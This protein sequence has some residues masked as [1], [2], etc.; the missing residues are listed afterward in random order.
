MKRN[1]II[2]H[3]DMDY[4][5]A[6]VEE[7]ENP[8]L[9]GKPVVVGADPKEGKGRGVVSTCN[10]EAREYGIH[11]GMPISKAYKLCKDCEF[12]PVNMDLYRAVSKR[13]MDMLKKYSEKYQQVS[14]DE[15]FLDISQNVNSFREAEEYAKRIK[16]DIKERED[17]TCSIGIGPNKLI[18]KIASDYEKPDGIT[19]IKPEK[20]LDFIYPMKVRKLWGVGPKTEEKL[21]EMGVKTIKDLSKTK[22]DIL[23]KE[24]GSLGH[25]LHLMSKGKDNSEVKEKEGIKSLGRETTFQEDISDGKIV[26]DEIVSL[27]ERTHKLLEK[28]NLFFRT[29]TVRIRFEDFETHTSSKTIPLASTSLNKMISV[30]EELA[31]KY[32]K[33]KR[34]IRLVGVRLSKFSQKEEQKVLA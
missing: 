21:N 16:E 32:I 15:I 28:E 27:C 26:L 4:F 18:A 1:R 5:Y 31:K 25:D 2:L 20:V 3:I 33:D 22:Q 9:K 7:R 6:A 34:K 13:I 12:L 8:C 10:Y 24:F 29:V 30:A 23:I 14:V 19:L 17:L 11:S